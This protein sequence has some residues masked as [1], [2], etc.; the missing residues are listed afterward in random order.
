MKK[1]FIEILCI[2]FI[3]SSFISCSNIEAKTANCC[4]LIEDESWLSDVY[5]KNNSIYYS[6]YVTV[7]NTSD[8]NVTVKLIGDLKEEYDTGI[9]KETTLCA[10]ND[11][12]SEY[13]NIPSNEKVSFDVV[14]IGTLQPDYQ[15]YDFLKNNRLLFPVTLEQITET[16]Y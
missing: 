4:R 5:I 11:E 9:I 10:I 2:I 12:S 1:I 6:C 15:K 16:N 13:F 3:L 8:K 7:K 14:F